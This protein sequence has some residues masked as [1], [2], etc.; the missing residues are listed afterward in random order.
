LKTE[1]AW[2]VA[3]TLRGERGPSHSRGACV[4]A[5]GALV[6]G[7]EAVQGALLAA[8]KGGAASCGRGGLRPSG[9]CADFR[10]AKVCGAAGAVAGFAG[11]RADCFVWPQ[12]GRGEA[13]CGRVASRS[14]VWTL[15]G[16]QSAC[17]LRRVLAK[18]WW[19][20]SAQLLAKP[21]S[22][23]SFCQLAL[24]CV[25]GGHAVWPNPACSGHG[26]AVGQRRRFVSKETSLTMLLGKHAVPLT[27]SLG[28]AGKEAQA[29]ARQG[30]VQRGKSNGLGRRRRP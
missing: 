8:K 2:F 13:E 3:E 28:T 16:Q 10:S 25:R 12:V 11:A 6:R 30:R 18:C 20:F 17:F 29:A 5:V 27:P 19:G 23:F 1:R 9:V 21:K 14:V 4:G 7:A 24:R 15:A 26:Y 22:V